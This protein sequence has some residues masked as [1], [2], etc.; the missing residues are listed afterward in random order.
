MTNPV[1]K[2]Q[3]ELFTEDAREHR[4]IRR[5]NRQKHL[6]AGLQDAF[7]K[8]NQEFTQKN[9]QAFSYTQERGASRKLVGHPGREAGMYVAESFG[10]YKIHGQV[11]TRFAGMNRTAGQGA[12]GIT[13][14]EIRVAVELV[15]T[16]GVSQ[17][18]EVPVTVKNGYM[19]QPGMFWCEGTPYILSQSAVDDVL[20]GVTFS[21]FPQP[22]RPS[23]FSPPPPKARKSASRDSRTAAPSS[24]DVVKSMRPIDVE[25]ERKR[26]EDDYADEAKAKARRKQTNIDR[27]VTEKPKEEKKKLPGVAA[28]LRPGA[29]TRLAE[30]F[31]VPVGDEGHYVLDKGT[32]AIVVAHV[33]DGIHIKH[34]SG[35]EVIVPQQYLSVS[36]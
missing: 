23:M 35:V 31:Y 17:L 12:H 25:R 22:D 16:S 32:R 29:L 9:A 19:L 3:T 2:T 18:L 20:E 28:N 11:K 8:E 36:S 5:A 7:A 27:G 34:A 14:G 24:S 30:E 21:K 1:R 15:P 10:E 4:R 13:D 26:K 33:D 6:Y